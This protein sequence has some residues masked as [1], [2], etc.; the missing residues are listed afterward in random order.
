MVHHPGQTWEELYEI[1]NTKV[2]REG[3]K[4][5][6]RWDHP[7]YPFRVFKSHGTPRVG[8]DVEYPRMLPV[9]DFRKVKFIAMSRNGPD[10]VGLYLH[11]VY[12]R[13]WPEYW[14]HYAVSMHK[15]L[16]SFNDKYWNAFGMKG[17]WFQMNLDDVVDDF[18]PGKNMEHTYFGY[19]RDWWNYRND[20]NVLLLHYSDM[21][22]D[23]RSSIKR[24][25]EFLEVSLTENE[26]DRVNDKCGIS[27][28]KSIKD[29]F[30]VRTY[31][32]PIVNTVL[33]HPQSCESTLIRTGQL[34]GGKE[35]LTEDQLARWQRYEA[36]A[37]Q[38]PALRNWAANGGSF[39]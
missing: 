8:D 37:F 20:E 18:A 32:S 36:A 12:T 14:L 23:Q 26:L 11:G 24:I 10:F 35:L 15:F 6:D 25:A 27:H 30:T 1:M 5:K 17:S 34:N 31:G 19:A 16:G 21:K 22:R 13:Y 28:M 9:R 39:V 3:T 33:C 4:L 38:D 2:L 7:E 29:R